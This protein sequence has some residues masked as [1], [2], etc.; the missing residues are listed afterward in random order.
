M[1]YGWIVLIVLCID[2]IVLLCGTLYTYGSI[3][4]PMAAGLG[5]TMTQAAAGQT[6]LS[7]GCSLV[8][9]AMG[10]V[11]GTKVQPKTFLLGAAL[12][13]MIGCGFMGF[14]AN[15][16]GIYYLCY[17][18]FFSVMNTCG[19][20]AVAQILIARWFDRKRSIA[21]A[22]HMSMGGI[23]GFFFPPFT[24]WLTEYTGN[25]RA[26]WIVVMSLCVLSF[27]LTSC[28]IK[29]SPTQIGLETERRSGEKG[30]MERPPVRVYRTPR[31]F[32]RKEA[33]RTRFFYVHILSQ[34]GV[35][36]STTTMGSFFIAHL[37]SLEIGSTDAAKAISVFAFMNFI[38]RLSSGFVQVYADPRNVLRVC[39]PLMGVC[40]LFAPHIATSVQAWIFAGL[41]GLG[42]SYSVTAPVNALMNVFGLDSYAKIAT[43]DNMITNIIKSGIVLLAGMIYDSQGSYNMFFILLAGILL[44]AGLLQILT[45]TPAHPSLRLNNK[46]K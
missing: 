32:T 1:I 20:A 15:G 17:A 22:I 30:E 7:I 36:V 37:I 25:W 31:S 9:L 40:L 33:F 44:V 39:L 16:A 46:T 3:L 14:I 28:F 45:K 24:T 18:V 6:I 5:L 34:I 23:G 42:F 38:G 2:H 43:A 8:G 21:I 29:N 41:F 19:T 26:I 27:L 11:L 4:L 35:Q 13:G 10:Q 12:S